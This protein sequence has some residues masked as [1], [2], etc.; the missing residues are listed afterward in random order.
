MPTSRKQ[1]PTPVPTVN[2]NKKA[3]NQVTLS[4]EAQEKKQVAA[5]K[6]P[7]LYA[8]TRQAPEE[9]FR[10]AGFDQLRAGSTGTFGASA[11]AAS[12][13]LGSSSSLLQKLHHK[14]EV[15]A[16][17]GG[18]PQL[19]AAVENGADAVYFGVSEFNAR[20]R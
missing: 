17:A 18:W 6:N 5:R 2:A 16:P 9:E 3:A 13:A 8:F 10:P 14:P 19:R 4:P 15:L 20:A 1:P 7:G 12:T 11:T